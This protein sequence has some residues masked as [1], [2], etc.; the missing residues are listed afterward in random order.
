MVE[1]SD[2]EFDKLKG[3]KT[4]VVSA[5]RHEEHFS[6][7]TYQ[8]AIDFIEKLENSNQINMT[9]LVSLDIHKTVLKLVQSQF[10][11]HHIGY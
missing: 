4:L 2:E 11:I 10:L 9:L 5:L 6:H 3:V 1:G 7:F 8:E